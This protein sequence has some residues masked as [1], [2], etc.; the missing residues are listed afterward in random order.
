VGYD[1]IYACQ[2]IEDDMK[3]GVKSTARRFG[4]HV[5]LGVFSSYIIYLGLLAIALIFEIA[6]SR[7]VYG[8]DISEQR[9]LPLALALIIPLP[10]MCHLMW[11]VWTLNPQD[12]KNSL[13]RFKSNGFAAAILIIT[14]II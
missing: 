6:L 11:Q 9:A 10:L 14:M 4:K 7:E 3:I 2:D 1:T 5:K 12:S 13:S 8:I